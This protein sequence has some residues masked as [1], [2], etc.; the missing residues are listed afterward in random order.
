MSRLPRAPPPGPGA[1]PA[2]TSTDELISSL[3]I[4]PTLAAVGGAH[5]PSYLKLDGLNLLPVLHGKSKSPRTEM[6]WHSRNS[7]AALVGNY[8]WVEAP[9]FS[10]LFDLKKDAGESQDLSAQRPDLVVQV[11]SRWD[12]WRREMD[13]AEPRGPFR[14]Y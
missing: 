12:N 2:N 3:D 14:D 7:K 1:I 6:F 10:G 8:K 11:K 13:E 4:F 9:S 5:L